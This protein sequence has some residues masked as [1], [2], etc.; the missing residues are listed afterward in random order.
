[1]I[2]IE[3]LSY[4]FQKQTLYFDTLGSPIRRPHLVLFNS[5]VYLL[6]ICLIAA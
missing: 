4:A 5:V 2:L 3:Y 1:M 6:F